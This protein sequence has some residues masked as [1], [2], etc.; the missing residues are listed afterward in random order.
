LKS[1]T[2]TY[3]KYFGFDESSWI[4]CEICGAKAVDI[5]H[6]EPRS[7][8]KAKLNLIDNLMALCRRCHEDCGKSMAMNETA[9]LIH[10][11]KLLSVTIE[12]ETKRY[13]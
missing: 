7:R 2:K 11:K 1:Y 12:H 6:L 3:F 4:P 5:H 10:R 9:K 8:V 13:I